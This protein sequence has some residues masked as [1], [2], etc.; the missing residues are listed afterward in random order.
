MDSHAVLR[1]VS[2]RPLYRVGLVVK[3]NYDIADAVLGKV[4]HRI[5]YERAIEKRDGW[6]GAVFRERPEPRP[7]PR[8]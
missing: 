3:I 5:R 7:E 4:L 2:E 8:C 6:L 1:P